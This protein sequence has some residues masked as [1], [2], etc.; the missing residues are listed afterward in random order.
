MNNLK[1]QDQIRK[2]QDEVKYDRRCGETTTR[3][4]LSDETIADEDLIDAIIEYFSEHAKSVR[5]EDHSII[6]DHS[7]I[8]PE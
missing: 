2:I 6:I 4:S 5:V 1:F 3:T 7:N 8:D